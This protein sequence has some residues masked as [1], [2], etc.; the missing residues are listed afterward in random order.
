MPQYWYSRNICKKEMGV[1]CDH[2]TAGIQLY[3]V[4]YLIDETC[5]HIHEIVFMC[6]GSIGRG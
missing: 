3:S 2:S 6:A 4:I 1:T 5:L